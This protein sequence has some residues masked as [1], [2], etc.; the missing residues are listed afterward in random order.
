MVTFQKSPIVAE[1][2]C[3]RSHP[4][5][6]PWCRKPRSEAAVALRSGWAL[7]R[8]ILSGQCKSGP[9]RVVA[10][11]DVQ[12][13]HIQRLAREVGTDVRRV[14]EHFGVSSLK[15]IRIADYLRV[16]RSLEKRRAA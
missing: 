16:V 5:M 13:I 6:A 14:L 11:P 1:T 9:Q 7:T 4:D 15:E 3:A 10:L 12:I 2:V 8:S